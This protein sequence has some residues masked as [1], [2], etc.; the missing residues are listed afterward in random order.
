MRKIFTL[1]AVLF[2]AL[3]ANAQDTPIYKATI[4]NV[5]GYA[6]STE[7]TAT[8]LEYSD[9]V[10]IK[11][12]DGKEGNDLVLLWNDDDWTSINGKAVAWV[13]YD[14][15][16]T[17]YAGY[18]YATDGHMS[19]G[20]NANGGSLWIQGYFYKNEQ[21]NN[22]LWS[23]LYYTWTAADIDQAVGIKAVSKETENAAAY[24]LMGQKVAADTKG[25]VIKNGVKTFNR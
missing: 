2:T 17:Y 19:A 4:K 1:F 24:N 11:G 20:W 22:P 6:L 3:V 12:Y 14:N 15:D 7:F 13:Y 21:D 8:F 23:Y 16:P 25:L 10:V 18:L 9:S 5:T